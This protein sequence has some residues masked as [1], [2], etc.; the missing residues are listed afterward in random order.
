MKNSKP[1]LT[2]FLKEKAKHL[3]K[4]WNDVPQ[5]VIE[6]S[7]EF[8][9]FNSNEKVEDRLGKYIADERRNH[10]KIINAL[11]KALKKNPNELVDYIEYD[12]GTDDEVEMESITMFQSVE[13]TF[14]VKAFCELI[15]IV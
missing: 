15:G 5:W 13:Y 10:Q 3:K 11:K 1:E 9:D 4:D 2:K 7:A 6:A 14:S 8:I 12:K